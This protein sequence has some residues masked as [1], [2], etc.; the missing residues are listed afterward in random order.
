MSPSYQLQV[1]TMVEAISWQNLQ[2][3]RLQPEVF[4]KFHLY[5]QFAVIITF[6]PD[7]PSE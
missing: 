2:D 6:D 4:Q 1:V 7:S 5:E 3:G